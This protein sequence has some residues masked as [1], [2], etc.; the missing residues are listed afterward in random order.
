MAK[1]IGN[2]LESIDASFDGPGAFLR[3]SPMRIRYHKGTKRPNA[4]MKNVENARRINIETPT[5]YR[6][7]EDG[8]VVI[9]DTT[10][11]KDVFSV[12]STAIRDIKYDPEDEI[13]S[14]QFTS[15]DKYYDYAVTPSELKQM[16]TA[17]SKGRHLN[18]VWKE[19]NRLPGYK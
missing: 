5:S 4:I 3:I 2:F 13:A 14:V 15:G 12:A 17:P 8:N 11:G 19:N 7:N 18:F 10:K 16:I 9:S 6:K 1:K